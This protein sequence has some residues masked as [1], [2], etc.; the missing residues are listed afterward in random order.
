MK[1]NIIILT[2]LLIF[3]AN[4][5]YPQ[6]GGLELETDLK[7]IDIEANANFGK[8]RAELGTTYSISEKKITELHTRLNMKPSD[9]YM[10]LECS[11]LT[12]KPIDDVV[13]VYKANNG[14]GWGA[15]AKELGIKPG[16]KEFHA[17]KAKV[18]TKA[19][20]KGGGKPNGN[21]P[22]GKPNKNKHK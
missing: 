2:V 11:Y 10:S 13:K 20:N 21:K 5:I 7:S 15:I 8:F 19:N 22:K 14:K 1:I 16:S 6:S 3:S 12:G 17:L 4:S 18:K 9:I